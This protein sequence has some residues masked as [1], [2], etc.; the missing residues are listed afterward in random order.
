MKHISL[1]LV[2]LTLTVVLLT[3]SGVVSPAVGPLKQPLYAANPAVLAD[4]VDQPASSNSVEPIPHPILNDVRIRR[5]IAYCTNKDALIASIYPTLTPEERE[6]LVMDTFVP[7]TS[8][9]YTPPT[10]T[11]PYSP[12]LGQNL[13][14]SA[15]WVL[16][17][18]ADYRVKDGKELVLLLNTTTSSTRVTYLTV[19]EAQMRAC[20]IRVIR[21]HQPASWWFG[22]TTGLHVRDFELGVFA[23]VSGDDPGGRELYA[24]DQ[25]PLPTNN[26]S[27]ANF[28]GWCNENASQAI[29]QASDT[30]RPQDQRRIF[31]ATF[32]NLFA[33][34]VPSLP[35]FLYQG[36]TAWEHIDFNLQT[37]AQDA[38]VAPDET[39]PA[40]LNYRDYNGNQHTVTV[41]PR[42]VTQ[43]TTLRYYPLVANANPPPDGMETANAFRLNAVINGM[44]Q[45]TFSFN[46]PITFTV[47][48]TTTDIV[49]I[50]DENSL[51]L[52]YWDSGTNSWQDAS[53]TC[54]VAKRYKRLDSAQN[55]F[56][57]RICHLTEFS[58][59]GTKN[60]RVYLPLIVR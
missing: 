50:F 16:P 15:G 59:M 49:D 32:I 39:D 38:E 45:D 17:S 25:I 7:K 35:L 1:P 11:Y 34:D 46:E 18:G 51:T 53:E 54:P 55:L 58:L 23:W 13:L 4:K 29:I 19:F 47:R 6:A 57:V 30:S 56:E 40:V 8:W 5:A 41:P 31:Y 36:R 26:W 37:F 27:G 33:D 22:T 20:G 2:R 28:I 3:L 44:P 24:C 10:T 60:Q 48:Y 52:H 21:N 42:L 12:T 14:D 43:T 9:A